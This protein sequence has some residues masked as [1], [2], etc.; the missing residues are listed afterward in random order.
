MASSH[1]SELDNIFFM[2]LSSQI[3]EAEQEGDEEVLD[4]LRQIA[5]VVNEVLEA[6][7]PPEVALIRRLMVMPSDEEVREQMEDRREVLTPRF[8][9]FLQV[10]ESSAREEGQPESADRIAEIRAVAESI[11]P[12]AASQAASMQA[13]AEQ[14]TAV[15]QP[16]GQPTPSRRR[17]SQGPVLLER[18]DD[19]EEDE[20]SSSEKRT[21]S[22]LIIPG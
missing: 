8:F 15:Q 22:G 18:E 21:P 20:G 16:A 3:E 17:P 7:M 1:L 9:L 10:F 12:E 14:P 2:V 13:E 6:D 5:Q 19:G 11:A 4:E